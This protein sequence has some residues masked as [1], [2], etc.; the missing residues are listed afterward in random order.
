MRLK[1]ALI[2][3]TVAMVALSAPASAQMDMMQFADPNGDGKVTAEEFT[4]FRE[5]G[6][7]FFSQGAEK[8][9][10]ADLDEMG[11]GAFTGVK[12]DADG[13]VTKAAY[14]AVTADRF[15]AADKNGDGTLDRDE[16]NNSMKPAG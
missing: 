15:K 6:W 11:K 2:A 14:M 16:I 5:G 8:V 3:S 7:N 1:L 12:P 10:L 13:T 4:A 9:K